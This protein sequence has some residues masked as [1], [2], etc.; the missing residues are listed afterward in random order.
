MAT[1]NKKEGKG[2]KKKN[3][4]KRRTRDEMKKYDLPQS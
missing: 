1:R 4:E 2:K 3:R